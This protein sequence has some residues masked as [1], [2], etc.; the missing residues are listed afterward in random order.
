MSEKGQVLQ[1]GFLL[2]RSNFWRLA[3]KDCPSSLCLLGFKR[4]LY[5]VHTTISQNNSLTFQGH[6]TLFQGQVYSCFWIVLFSFFSK[7]CQGCQRIKEFSHLFASHTHGHGRK[8]NR[9]IAQLTQRFL[10]IMFATWDPVF[11]SH[12]TVPTWN[13]TV[14]TLTFCYCFQYKLFTRAWLLESRLNLTNG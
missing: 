8:I 14:D 12:D 13:Y 4:S 6:L 10:F 7:G 5:M 2:F 11:C 3:S 9:T 1:N